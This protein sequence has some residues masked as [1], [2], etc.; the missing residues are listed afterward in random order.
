VEQ[1]SVPAAQDS[2]SVLQV[3]PPGVAAHR[4]PV[5]TVEQHWAPPEQEVPIAL[6]AVAL[7]VVLEQFCE[8]QSRLEAQVAPVPLQNGFAHL[9]ETQLPVQHCALEVQE[10]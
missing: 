2:P 7:H 5:H 10:A 6:H 1:Q 4:P 9:P 8:Q 3:P